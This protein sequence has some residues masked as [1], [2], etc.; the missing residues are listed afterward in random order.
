MSVVLGHGQRA[1]GMDGGD[2]PRL[3]VADRLPGGGE[4]PAV[5]AAGGDDLTHVGPFPAGDH[6]R[7]VGVEVAGG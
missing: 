6:D 3:P 5:V 1:V 2:G 4:Q 7:Q